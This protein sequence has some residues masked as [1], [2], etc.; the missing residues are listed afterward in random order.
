[1]NLFIAPLDAFAFRF[2]SKRSMDRITLE[3]QA[4]TI[5]RWKAKSG[6]TGRGYVPV[7][8]GASR[9]PSKR[10]LLEALREAERADR[11]MAQGARLSTR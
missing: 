10:A 6:V 7:N 4:R 5:E 1:M 9:T 11:E 8:S 2:R 3:P